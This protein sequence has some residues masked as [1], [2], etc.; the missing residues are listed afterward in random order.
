MSSA[1]LILRGGRKTARAAKKASGEAGRISR[2]TCRPLGG[3]M[4]NSR[5]KGAV[6]PPFMRTLLA[7]LLL[8]ALASTARADEKPAEPAPPATE[9]TAPAPELQ[10]A[11]E[12]SSESAPEPSSES[13]PELAPP[14]PAATPA[15][16]A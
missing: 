6:H 7:T 14:T 4:R 3:F 5:A 12:P 15:P 10:A 8:S 11:P 13:A 16:A 1:S 2:F 9:T